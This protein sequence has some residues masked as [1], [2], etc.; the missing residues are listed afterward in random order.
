[1]RRQPQ[2]HFNPR[3][4]PL[5]ARDLAF[6]FLSRASVPF[7]SRHCRYAAF[8]TRLARSSKFDGI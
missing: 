7:P 2:H 8:M 5:R 4:R 3:R 6:A 1:M